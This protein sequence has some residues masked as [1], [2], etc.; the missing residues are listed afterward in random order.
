MT[1]PLASGIILTTVAAGILALGVVALR[2]PKPVPQQLFLFTNGIVLGVDGV[3]DPYAWP[4]LELAEKVVVSTVGSKRREVREKV[5]LI[6]PLGR[7]AQFLVPS[8]HRDAVAA[9]AR[10][11]GATIR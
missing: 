4:D 11:G 6:G 1:H 10:A 8:R 2:R 3:L 7:S 5:L 9:L